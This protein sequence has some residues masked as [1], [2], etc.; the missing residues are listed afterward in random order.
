MGHNISTVATQQTTTNI[1]AIGLTGAQAVTLGKTI[2]NGNI[3]A[4]NASNNML[5]TAS[6]NAGSILDAAGAN[7]NTLAMAGLD[8]V[9]RLAGQVSQ[10][11]AQQTTGAVQLSGQT[12]QGVLAG[13]LTNNWKV[14]LGIAAAIAAGVWAFTAA[15]R[16]R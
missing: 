14:W 1:G 2:I 10:I 15:K 13:G 12:P 16:G 8:S 3:A 4:V 11:A 9:N 7:A 6:S 5:S